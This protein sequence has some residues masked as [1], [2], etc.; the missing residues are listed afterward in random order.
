[1]WKCKAPLRCKITLCLALNNKLLTWD[2]GLKRGWCGPN[3]C[4]LCKSSVESIAHL[5]ISCPYAGQ[6]AKT[7]KDRLNARADWNKDII[8]DC[9]KT[10]ILDRSVHLYAGLPSLM[11]S[12]IWWAHN[13]TIFMD[14]W[15]DPDATTTL[16]LN[17]AAKFKEDPKGQKT[18]IP[19]LPSLDYRIPWGYFNGASQGHL[20]SC[21]V[22]VALYIN[23]NHYIYIRYA[24]GSG[25]NNKVELATLWTL[26][27]TAIKDIRKLQILGDSK[28]VIDWAQGKIDIQNTSL[29]TVMR[30][31]RLTFQSFEWLSFHHILRELNLKADEL[32]K[33]VSNIS[34]LYRKFRM[35]RR[36]F[37]STE[38]FF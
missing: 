8:E 12:N 22:G 30:E 28:L 26:L 17:Q 16:T 9:F 23:Q 2:N 19:I 15:V 10:W 31:I 4:V 1:M 24:P 36:H 27:E 3:K 35:C 18:R 25:T 21:G 5:F 34:T 14:R 33:A 11:I 29:A 7:V 37:H 20:P 32:S 13:S 38:I 6:V